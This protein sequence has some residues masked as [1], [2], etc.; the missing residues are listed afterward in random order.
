[1]PGIFLPRAFSTGAAKAI[2]VIYL[3]REVEWL[4]QVSWP[5]PRGENS[6]FT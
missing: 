4:Q 5:R 6:V 3:Q 2:D 1:M